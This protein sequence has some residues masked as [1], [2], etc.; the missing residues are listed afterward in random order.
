MIAAGRILAV[1]SEK[2]PFFTGLR[3]FAAQESTKR[4]P[5]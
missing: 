5:P 2:G 3:G 4:N 1:E